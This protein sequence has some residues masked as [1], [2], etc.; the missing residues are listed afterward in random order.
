MRMGKADLG[1]AHVEGLG[2]SPAVG[3][4]PFHLPGIP[5]QLPV[6]YH[7]LTLHSIRCMLLMTHTMTVALVQQLSVTNELQRCFGLHQCA[8][9]N[10]RVHAFSLNLLV[11]ACKLLLC[12]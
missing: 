2:C 5:P 11:M 12:S 10:V 1:L 6:L 3:L 8:K 4:P 9:Q 7:L